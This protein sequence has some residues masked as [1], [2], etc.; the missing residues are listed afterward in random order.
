ML[1]EKCRLEEERM[2]HGEKIKERERNE[3]EN[4]IYKDLGEGI[5]RNEY[6]ERIPERE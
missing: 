6:A 2:V 3:R 5:P 4:S 1:G